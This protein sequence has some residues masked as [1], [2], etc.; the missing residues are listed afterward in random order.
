VPVQGRKTARFREGLLVYDPFHYLVLTGETQFDGCVIEATRE[1]PYL[2]V[3]LDIPPEVVAKTL[4][5]LADRDAMPDR[6]AS[7]DEIPAFVSA[8]DEPIAPGIHAVLP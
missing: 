6:D 5:A 3:C 1:K 2:G 4:L 8:L 7:S